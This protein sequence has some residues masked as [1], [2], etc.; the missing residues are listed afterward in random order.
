MIDAIIHN[1][2]LALQLLSIRKSIYTIISDLDLEY[3]FSHEPITLKEAKELG[4]RQINIGQKWGKA[5][6]CSWFKI[7]GKIPQ[8]MDNKNLALILMLGGEGLVYNSD[9]EPI[10][11]LSNPRT[12]AS[13]FSSNS[14]KTVHMLDSSLKYGDDFTFYA[15]CTW[16][17]SVPNLNIWRKSKVKKAVLAYKNQ[18][19]YDFYYN[20]YALA[21]FK[22]SLERIKKNK[23]QKQELTN[24]LNK[25]FNLY[26]K[27]LSKANQIILDELKKTQKTDTQYFAIGHGHLDLAWLW[28][29]R[30]TVRK[31]SR[32]LTHAVNNINRYDN[33]IFGLSQPVILE[34]MQ[35]K[36]PTIFAS[37]V[38]KIKQDRIELQGGFFIECDTNI[39]GG[40]S[41]VRQGL[42]G[43]EFYKKHFNTT[44]KTCWLPDVF[45]FTGSLPQIIQ[46]C[47]ME[48]FMSIKLS[49]NKYNEFPYDTF[50]W[51]GI[52]G[53]EV[54][55]HFPPEGN[56]NSSGNSVSLGI[57]E[58]KKKQKDIKQ[59]LLIYGEGDGG[60]GP[61]EI[62]I[63]SVKRLQSMRD[64][65]SV[66]FSKAIDFFDNL[67]KSTKNLPVYKGELYLEK[68][69]GTLTT[70]AKIKKN[71]R[72]LERILHNTEYLASLV[73]LQTSKFDR[74]ELNSV[75]REFLVL[76]FHDIL[77]G[78]SINRVYVEAIAKAEELKNRLNQIDKELFDILVREQDDKSS[79]SE[80]N[81]SLCNL[82]PYSRDEFIKIDN[83]WYRAKLDRYTIDSI[84][85]F[86]F[87]NEKS[88]ILK[89]NDNSIE[90]DK[91]LVKFNKNGEVFSLLN[92]Q[93]NI[94]YSNGYL[95][96]L[97]VFKDK[98]HILF[99]AWDID[100]KY[101]KRR[102]KILKI[103]SSKTYIDGC[104]IVRENT[105]SFGKSKISQK[106]VLKEN[107]EILE[108]DTQVDWHTKHKMLRAEFNPSVK[109]DNAIF[110]IQFGMLE[111]SAKNET[112][113]EKAMFEA[114]MQKWVAYSN[115]NNTFAI[116]NDCKYGARA[117]DGLISINLLRSAV[118]PDKTADRGVQ[119]FRYGIYAS[120]SS[121]EKSN[122][123]QHG[124]NFNNPIEIKKSNLSI[125]PIII[126]DNNSV[127][128][129]TIKV[130]ENQDGLIVRLFE[131]YG[132]ATSFKLKI[133][134]KYKEI[135]ET[136][137]L[138]EKI[139][140][141]EPS[142]IE[143]NPFEIKTIK[144]VF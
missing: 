122:L 132:N 57:S 11:A 48:Y 99:N 14:G 143:I 24:K 77:P 60:G 12:V 69:Q 68:H 115:K 137:M 144:I 61:G 37:V 103:M 17:G 142:K 112:S 6:D 29:I 124:Y 34:W 86:N 95:N 26:K 83:M 38:E 79:K 67:K 80:K 25:A 109:S 75:W 43:Q 59:T 102:K 52:D 91:L 76:Q 129:E 58:R 47:G 120:N 36:Y 88:K 114:A 51:K 141:I 49:W 118:F 98:K 64:L 65:P 41:L 92:K 31:A 5:F 66:H 119:N 70:H 136:N 21:C 46:K 82:S 134:K 105:Y 133:N 54:L 110:D 123:V 42:Y 107:S 39:V 116:L 30:E 89:I 55:S 72:D 33:Y 125:K 73:F 78:S 32:T 16:N 128:L 63:E 85:S 18:D 81:Q 45:G 135:F 121:L 93:T 3:C 101:R 113:H 74:E 117:K 8:N 50:K 139:G 94:E 4:F 84:N 9:E 62:H 28:P 96:R 106:I 126:C 15:D 111:R 40:E 71:N 90:N 53:T 138:E 140:I 100:I 27:D 44:I 2:K 108:F 97:I 130:A 35:Q 20:Y 19:L 104:S 7:T 23:A 56:Y 1:K 87:I 131:T 127:I 22:M 13:Y 10:F